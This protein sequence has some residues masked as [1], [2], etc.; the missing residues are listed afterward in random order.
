M[1][2]PN[3]TS[4]L[5]KPNFEKIGQKKILFCQIWPK[6]A[7]NGEYSPKLPKMCQNKRETAKIAKNG[8]K[9]TFTKNSILRKKWPKIA[10]NGENSQKTPK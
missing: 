3:L 10:P 7:F 6:I 4:K 1:L 2:K 5:A 8:Q 9:L